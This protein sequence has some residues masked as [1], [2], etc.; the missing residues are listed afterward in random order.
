VAEMGNM[1][2]VNVGS[3]VQGPI[4]PEAV[5]VLAIVPMG[6]SVKLIAAVR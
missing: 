5:E 6:E 1:N 4:L 2:E 3:I